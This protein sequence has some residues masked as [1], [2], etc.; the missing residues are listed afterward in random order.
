MTPALTVWK[1]FLRF[2]HSNHFIDNQIKS[3]K[4]FS[5]FHKKQYKNTNKNNS[6]CLDVQSKLSR[7][8]CINIFNIVVLLFSGD[9]LSFLS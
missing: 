5:K 8:F 1:F 6:E 2:L 4:Q 3:N 7:S 9:N